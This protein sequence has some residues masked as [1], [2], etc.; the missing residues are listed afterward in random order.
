MEQ[1]RVLTRR[2]LIRSFEMYDK[3]N[4]LSLGHLVDITTKGMMLI[5]EKPLETDAIYQLRMH[6]PKEIDG[7]GHVDYRARALWGDES[8]KEDFLIQGLNWRIS[9]PGL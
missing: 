1:K 4:V 9:H 7:G 6:L 8:V 3:P 5:S 2:H